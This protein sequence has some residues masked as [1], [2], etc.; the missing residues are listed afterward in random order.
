MWASS[1][2]PAVIRSTDLSLND[3]NDLPVIGFDD[4]ELNIEL[5]PVP[6]PASILFFFPAV[7]GLFFVREKFKHTPNFPNAT[8]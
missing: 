1:L 8:C 4:V 7:T 3:I 5:T 6:L 2:Y